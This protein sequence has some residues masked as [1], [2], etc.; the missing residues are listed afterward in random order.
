MK[1]FWEGFTILHIIMNTCDSRKTE[2]PAITGS[3]KRLSSTLIDHRG[4]HVFSGGSNCRGS[5]D[6]K[7]TRI[8]SGA[9]R[10]DKT[11]TDKDSCG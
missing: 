3:W 10:H 2:I 11:Q 1:I 7:G 4:V 8:R 6:S 5:G 9:W